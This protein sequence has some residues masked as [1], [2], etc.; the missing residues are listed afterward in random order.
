MSQ[1][2]ANRPIDFRM[3]HRFS[4]I[5]LLVF[6]LSFTELYSQTT[7]ATPTGTFIDYRD[8][9]TYK[10]IKIG[11]QTWMAENLRFLPAVS[12]ASPDPGFWIYGYSENNI[13]K[14]TE[15]DN[16]KV[17]GCLYSLFSDAVF[18]GAGHELCPKG[19]RLP[20]DEDWMTLEKECGL[21]PKDQDEYGFRI[22]GET[23]SKL[24]SASGWGPSSGKPEGAGNNNGF[25][26][27]PGGTYDVSAKVNTQV[28][29]G[30]GKEAIF[31]TTT[32]SDGGSKFIVVRTI[33]MDSEGVGKSY[34]LI[35]CGYSVR[36]IKVIKE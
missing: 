5:S 30:I 12:P 22:S 36:C 25:N 26:A 24:K 28:F 10:W 16:Y 29:N 3:Y 31:L 13:T 11:T 6:M 21:D 35:D 9:H 20:S 7:G 4:Q 32:Y 19:W 33:K 17:Y 14:A 8:G 34:G 1:N 15:S 18:L 27:L 2:Y 23:G